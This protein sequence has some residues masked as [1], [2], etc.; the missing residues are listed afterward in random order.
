M[1]Q[2]SRPTRGRG[3]GRCGLG[4]GDSR[5]S[6]SQPP[7]PSAP[8]RPLPWPGRPRLAGAGPV[9]SPIHTA[10]R[11]APPGRSPRQRGRRS[12]GNDFQ[13]PARPPRERAR[14]VPAAPR[15]PA[16]PVPFP[17]SPVHPRQLPPQVLSFSPPQL[18]KIDSYNPSH[19]DFWSDFSF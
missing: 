7:A 13:L 5:R 6:R 10:A 12:A 8:P 16:L 11:L 2:R 14:R 19:A 18:K 17:G 3:A 9:T 4:G 15:V 1:R